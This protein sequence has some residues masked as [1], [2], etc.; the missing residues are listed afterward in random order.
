MDAHAQEEIRLYAE[1]IGHKIVQ[2]LFPLVW[3]AFL[4][5][6]MF[7]TFLSRL[8]RGV[9]QRLLQSGA[10]KKIAPPYSEQDFLAAQDVTWRE[11]T[12][13]RE[14]DECRE[15]LTDLGLLRGE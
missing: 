8:E 13:S 14:R 2:P 9:M 10:E 7:G 4:D 3:E 6:R 11:F 15:K 5:Y 12:R 1:T